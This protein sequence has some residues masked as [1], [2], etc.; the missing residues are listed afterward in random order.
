MEHFLKEISFHGVML[1]NLFYADKKWKQE[2]NEV[3]EEA[4]REGSVKPL[5]RTIFT[6]EELEQAFR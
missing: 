5:V 1:D 4:I 2:L 6:A 3:V